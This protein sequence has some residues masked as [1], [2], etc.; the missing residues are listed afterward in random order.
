[1]IY[2]DH[3]PLTYLQGMRLLDGWLA[4]TL[5]ELGDYDFELKYLPGKHNVIADALSRDTLGQP[6]SFG[7]D[8]SKVVDVCRVCRVLLYIRF[9]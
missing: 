6:V 1:M 4:R 8:D 5:E 2:T 7:V 9:A 3:K